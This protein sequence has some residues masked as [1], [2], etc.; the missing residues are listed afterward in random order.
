DLLS[1]SYLLPSV[2]EIFTRTQQ[3]ASPPNTSPVA[4]VEP[5]TMTT[6]APQFDPQDSARKQ[7]AVSDIGQQLTRGIGHKIIWQARPPSHAAVGAR[8]G[9]SPVPTAP[10]HDLAS[11]SVLTPPSQR[12]VMDVRSITK[13]L[14]LGRERIEIL[15]GIS[16]QIRSGELVAIVGPS[17]SGKST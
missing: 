11:P 14:P 17:G 8:T 10:A 6:S 13:S 15:K 9:A 5:H 2:R 7:P 16:F 4:L 12:V 3:A 1:T